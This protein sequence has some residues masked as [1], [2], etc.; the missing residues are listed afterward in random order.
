MSAGPLLGRAGRSSASAV[1]RSRP[2]GLVADQDVAEAVA[3]LRVE[4][5]EKGEEVRIRVN[6]VSAVAPAAS[7]S[8]VAALF[9]LPQ[10]VIPRT[11]PVVTV[12]DVSDGVGVVSVTLS[13]DPHEKAVTPFLKTR[14]VGGSLWP[15]ASV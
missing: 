9:P 2:V 8:R 15:S 1:R 12:I 5:A 7:N 10:S 14:C 6:H 4:G 11:S 13:S 3:S